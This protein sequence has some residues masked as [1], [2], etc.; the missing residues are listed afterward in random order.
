VELLST[1]RRVTMA[2]VDAAGV[3]Y[4]GAPYPWQEQLYTEFLAV[5]GHP[6]GRLLAAGHGT[7][8]VASSATYRRPLALDDLVKCV[9]VAE[10]IGRS[11]FGLRMDGLRDDDGELAIQVSTRQVWV[12][13]EP[14]GRLAPQPV[15]AWL[16]TLL[17]G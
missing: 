3:L 5:S 13:L 17:G 16:R 11:S 6:L 4:V 14:G 15:P 1:I 12:A 9:L 2:D 8:Y 7:P 10:S